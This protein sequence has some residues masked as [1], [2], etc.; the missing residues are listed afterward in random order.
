MA[1][2]MTLLTTLMSTP[3]PVQAADGLMS[4]EQTVRCAGL[5]QAASELEGGESGRGQSLFDAALYWSLAATQAA[6]ASGRPA[7]SADGDQT[8]ARV[9]AVREL[10]DDDAGADAALQACLRRTPD[11]G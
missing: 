1:M 7:A 6:S 10:S 4:Y 9:T 3:A 11:L 8:R 2:L 5:T